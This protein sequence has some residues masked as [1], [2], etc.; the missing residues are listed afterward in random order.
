MTIKLES[1]K[2]KF[3]SG[4]KYRHVNRVMYAPQIPKQYKEKQGLNIAVKSE[5]G[6]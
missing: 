2:L 6:C 4:F 5:I 1:I 3:N